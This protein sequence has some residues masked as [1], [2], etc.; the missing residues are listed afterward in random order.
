MANLKS[1]RIADPLAWLD[2]L[3]QSD[4]LLALAAFVGCVCWPG[5][6]CCWYAGPFARPICRCCW[7]AG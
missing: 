2:A 7:G 5:A 3:A 4:T 1:A 6:Q